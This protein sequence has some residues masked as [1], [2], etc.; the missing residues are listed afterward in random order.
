MACLNQFYDATKKHQAIE[1]MLKMAEV[2]APTGLRRSVLLRT[3]DSTNKQLSSLCEVAKWG[4]VTIAE[5]LG[6]HYLGR[7]YEL[8]S[9]AEQFRVRVTLQV[10][11]SELDGSDALIV[12]AAD[13]LDRPGRSGLIA[14][15]LQVSKP[16][17]VTMTMSDTK[18]VPDLSRSGRGRSYWA[19]EATIQPCPNNGVKQ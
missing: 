5:D 12:D 10:V 15:L 18:D 17:L 19:S 6:I 11:F 9:A 2:L 1:A 4:T 3:I 8:L 7:A 14:L 16:A 13:I